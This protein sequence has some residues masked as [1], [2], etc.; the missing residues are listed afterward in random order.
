[1]LVIWLLVKSYS[2]NLAIPD[3]NRR[4]IKSLNSSN[5]PYN[6]SNTHDYPIKFIYPEMAYYE[7]HYKEKDFYGIVMSVRIIIWQIRTI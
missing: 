2:N 4:K 3:A 1:M 6:N 7:F 5:L